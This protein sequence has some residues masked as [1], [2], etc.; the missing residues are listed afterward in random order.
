MTLPTAPS[1]APSQIPPKDLEVLDFEIV[2]EDWNKYDLAD[3]TVLKARIVLARIGRPKFGPTG[4][5]SLASQTLFAV[6]A[7]PEKRGAPMEIPPKSEL[8]GLQKEPVKILTSSEPWN[9]YR[10]PKT[11]DILQIKLVVSEVFRVKDRFDTFG[12]PFYFVTSGPL[13]SPAAKGSVTIGS[14]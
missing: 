11:G 1:P 7:P 8:E 4:Q 9:K 6:T 12:E 13:V 5:F 3:Y 2:D 10:I 14:D